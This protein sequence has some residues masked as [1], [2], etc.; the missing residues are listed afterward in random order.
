M[1]LKDQLKTAQK[2]KDVENIYRAAIINSLDGSEITSPYSVDGLLV[3]KTIRTLLEFK[4]DFDFKNKTKQ[5]DVLTQCLF[6]LKKF[7]EDG[8]KVPSTIFIGDINEC[9]AI[10][11]NSIIKY[12]SSDIDWKIAASQAS[13][14]NPDLIM[15]M[16]GDTDIMP[17]VYNVDD[18]FNIK[19]VLEKI[20]DLSDNIVK[21]VR[22]TTKNIVNIFDLKGSKV[23]R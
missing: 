5:C 10:H 20:K 9:F 23:N 4:Y 19:D 1:N 12:L 17:F 6:Y 18:N 13:S 8:I 16:V 15:A 7:E 21:K 14:K 2:E 11:T 22:I 3:N